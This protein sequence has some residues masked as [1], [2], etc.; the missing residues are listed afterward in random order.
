[1]NLKSKMIYRHLLAQ[2]F[3]CDFFY[4]ELASGRAKGKYRRYEY[5]KTLNFYRT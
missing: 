3:A 2:T 1:M 5:I 4:R